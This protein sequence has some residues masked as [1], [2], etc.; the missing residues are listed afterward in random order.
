MLGGNCVMANLTHQQCDALRRLNPNVVSIW[1]D[2][3]SDKDGNSI[4]YDL[5]AVNAEVLSLIHI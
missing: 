3:A 1:G 2:Q 4:S 5:N